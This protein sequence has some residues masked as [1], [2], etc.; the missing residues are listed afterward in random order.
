MRTLDWISVRRLLTFTGLFIL[1][2]ANVQA[3]ERCV[4]ASGKGGC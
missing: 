3:A 4:D 1:A 2:S